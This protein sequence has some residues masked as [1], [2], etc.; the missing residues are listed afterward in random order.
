[1]I[2]SEPYCDFEDL[3][4]NEGIIVLS[5]SITFIIGNLFNKNNL[6]KYLNDF[7]NYF[8]KNFKNDFYLEIQ[9][10][11]DKNEKNLKNLI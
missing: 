7:T 8:K 10:H 1:M 5:G 9:R 11:N 2:M 3:I 6:M 4:N